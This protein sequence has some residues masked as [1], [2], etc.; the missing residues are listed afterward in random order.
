MTDYF[1]G[2]LGYVYYSTAEILFAGNIGD[3]DVLLAYGRADQDNEIGVFGGHLLTVPSATSTSDALDG[4]R[5]IFE[6]PGMLVLFADVPTAH[7]FFAP[8]LA[9]P[10][11]D[12]FANFWGFGTNASVLVGGPYLVRDAAYGKDKVVAITGDLEKD[13]IITVIGPEDMVGVTWN[14]EPVG[15]DPEAS[16]RI[17]KTGVCVGGLRLSPVASQITVP[18]LEGW[19]YADSLPERAREFDDSEWIVA[20]KTTT[21]SWKPPVYGDG[22]V[23]YGCDYGLYVL[24]FRALAC[25]SC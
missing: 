16:E 3:R 13:T 14:G 24:P 9:G 22:R 15:C 2:T 1:Y 20:D 17:S 12:S 5:P 7:T 10:P 19:H 8:P 11:E 6:V 25:S 23:L 4:V 18:K 21:N